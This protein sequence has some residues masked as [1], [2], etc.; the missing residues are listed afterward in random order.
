MAASSCRRPRLRYS[1]TLASPCMVPLKAVAIYGL[2]VTMARSWVWPQALGEAKPGGTCSVLPGSAT[3]RHDCF[4]HDRADGARAA[5]ALGVAAETAVNLAGGAH[6]AVAQHVA[7]A[8]D[9]EGRAF[10]SG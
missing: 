3:G 5:A 7:G 4:V 2:R 1:M 9:H 6:V 8:D 10:R